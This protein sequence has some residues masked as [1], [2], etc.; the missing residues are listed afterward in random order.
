MTYDPKQFNS[1]RVLRVFGCAPD[2]HIESSN[3]KALSFREFCS[4]QDG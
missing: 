1:L 3:E 4:H 2:F